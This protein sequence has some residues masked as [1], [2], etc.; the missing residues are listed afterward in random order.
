MIKSKR[1]PLLCICTMKIM[2]LLWFFKNES[3]TQLEKQTLRA[4]I[5]FLWHKQQ[6]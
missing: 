5:A 1:N 2:V 6:Q 4:F 3:F